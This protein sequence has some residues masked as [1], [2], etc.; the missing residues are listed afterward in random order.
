MFSNRLFLLLQLAGWLFF[1]AINFF[2]RSLVQGLNWAEFF[3]TAVLI[4][5]GFIVSSVLRQF[6]QRINRNNNSLLRLILVVISASV[7]AG[8]MTT[9][10]IFAVL[11]PL[12]T[13]VFAQ[14]S[15]FSFISLL[16][17]F[18]NIS[19]VMLVWSSLYF[20]IKRYRNY[21]Q[22]KA[23]KKQLDAALKQVSLESL[24]NQLNPHFMF[25]TINN[26]RALILEDKHKARDML[27]HLADMYRY[28]LSSQENQLVTLN[29]ELT[30]IDDYL[31]LM[32]IQLEQR[33]HT[34]FAI[35]NEA[36]AVYIPRMMLQ[37][38][39]ENGIKYGIANNKAG[40]KLTV[41][42][43]RHK[44]QLFLEI[45]NTGKLQLPSKNS[46]GIGLSNIKKRLQLLYSSA[47]TIELTEQAD[48]VVVTIL[49]PWNVSH[50]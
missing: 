20:A 33:L 22:I 37:L 44:Q 14:Q 42:A 17:N 34:E 50:D 3:S 27:S 12:S 6:Y 16:S 30:M 31:A 35:V 5:T 32:A 7:V 45:R 1:G 15:I 28:T 26:I 8:I 39:I 41:I 49:L 23:E 4:I 21:E 13:I 9:A 24:I 29:D 48:E 19:F 18:V 36:K 46:T 38:L 40:G 11:E 43:Q 2:S 10:I 25:N 47:A